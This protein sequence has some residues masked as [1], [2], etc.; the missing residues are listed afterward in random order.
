MRS[1]SQNNASRENGKQSH[2]ATTPEGQRTCCL[3][4]FK[5]G[6]TGATV[7]YPHEDVAA[8]DKC[9]AI[10]VNHYRPV[11]DMEKLIIQEVADST[12]KLQRVTVFESGIFAKG[13]M[14]N[15]CL[16]GPDIVNPQDRHIIVE[17][18]IAHTYSRTLSNLSMQ[19]ARAQHMLEKKI[20]QFEKMRAERE[21]VELAQTNIVMNSMLGDKDDH[22][23]CDAR[24]GVVF[25]KEFLVARIRFEKAVGEDDLAIFDRTWSDKMAKTAN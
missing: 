12:W 23:P 1:E 16:Y 15:Q 5:H 11:T 3:N 10:V 14:E 17:G 22:R 20:T 9:V 7:L 13:R 18:E 24:V 25:S 21:V 2:G 8:Y 6:L 19:Q 4:A